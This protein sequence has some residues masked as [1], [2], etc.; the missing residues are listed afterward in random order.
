MLLGNHTGGDT[1]GAGSSHWGRQD[2]SGCPSAGLLP[3]REAL[4]TLS[5]P[6]GG[7]QGLHGGRGRAVAPRAEAGCEAEG[8]KR[9]GLAAWCGSPGPVPFSPCLC[10]S[11]PLCCH[12]GRQEPILRLSA[13][14]RGSGPPAARM[15]AA[16]LMAARQPQME[17]M[18]ADSGARR[19]SIGRPGGTDADTA[20]VCT[21]RD[22]G[23]DKVPPVALGWRVQ[24]W[25]FPA[26]GHGPRTGLGQGRSP[27]C[28]T[29]A[30]STGGE[31]LQPE[32]HTD[33]AGAGCRTLPRLCR[34]GCKHTVSVGS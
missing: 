21:R 13:P 6:P 15:R 8:V 11:R 27:S 25:P 12:S 9:D 3:A 28:P 34:H 22:G 1:A 32:L 18:A 19:A 4:A 26:A 14:G 17:R 24:R 5:C 29:R 30:H 10:R 20:F 33:S 2:P 7:A 23:S 16:P 31:G